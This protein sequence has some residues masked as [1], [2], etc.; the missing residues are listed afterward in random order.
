MSL[1]PNLYVVQFTKTA[2]KDY[3]AIRERKLKRGINKLVDKLKENPYQF[4]KLSPPFSHLRSAK[5]FSF[6]LLYQVRNNILLVEVVA[7]GDR[8]DIYRSISHLK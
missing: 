8:K 3:K 6:R 7:I 1:P 2:K 4:K 5:T